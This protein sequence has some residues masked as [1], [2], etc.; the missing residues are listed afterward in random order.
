MTPVPAP[1]K[2][3]GGPKALAYVCLIGLDDDANAILKESFKQFG[4]ETVAF[5]A[6]EALTRFKK[7]KFEA[8]V[9]NLEEDVGALLASI[10]KNSNTQRMVIYGICATT[11]QALKY[12]R[13]GINA[14]FNDPVERQNVLRVV[15]ATHLLVLHELRRYVRIP[16]VTDVEIK[17]EGERFKGTMIEISGGGM[18]MQVKAPLKVGDMV[19]AYF[20]LPGSDELSLRSTVAWMRPDNGTGGIRYDPQDPNR[21]FIKDWIEDYLDIE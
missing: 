18:S 12:S 10:R 21:I 16:L 4:I 3:S 13:Y 6:E 14:M 1:A 17:A 19:E 2:S 9:L 8:G 5:P 15:R 20:R 7:V 11:Q